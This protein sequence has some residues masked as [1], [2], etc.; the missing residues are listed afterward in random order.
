LPGSHK[1]VGYRECVNETAAYRLHIECRA[2]PDAKLGLQ[3]AGGAR[4]YHVRCGGGDDDQIDIVRIETRGR[5]RLAAGL[6]RKVAGN[7]AV[8]GDMTLADAG[9]RIYPLIRSIDQFF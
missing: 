3:D 7:F 4:K 5:D 6:K 1:L 9:S 2:V 8:G